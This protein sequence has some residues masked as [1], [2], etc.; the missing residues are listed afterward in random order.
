MVALPLNNDYKGEIQL[1]DAIDFRP[2][3]NFSGANA[4][5]LASVTSGV[6]AQSAGNFR[7]S[8][9]GGVGFNSS[10]SLVD[11]TFRCDIEYYQGR[12]DSLFLSSNG[13]LT[14]P[15]VYTPTHPLLLVTRST[16]SVCMTWRFPLTPSPLV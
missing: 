4:S 9:N 16:P 6:D 15:R 7:D 5:V 8:S 2:V 12:I 11:S 14:C 3:I 10:S 1:R 13:N